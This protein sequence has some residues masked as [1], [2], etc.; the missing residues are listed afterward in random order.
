MKQNKT[1]DNDFHIMKRYKCKFLNIIKTFQELMQ[2]T[3]IFVV[4][5]L[6]SNLREVC[7]FPN[8]N[9]A[10]S[11]SFLLPV[12]KPCLSVRA[13]AYTGGVS[14]PLKMMIPISV[15][16]IKKKYPSEN[17]MWCC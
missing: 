3:Y 13:H 16:L 9:T 8:L 14:K 4:V 12:I 5:H 6:V 10:D 17:Q 11:P 1:A 2:T 15:K 7:L